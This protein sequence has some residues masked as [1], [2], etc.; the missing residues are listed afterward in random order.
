M[1]SAACFNLCFPSCF[2]FSPN[3]LFFCSFSPFF[4]LR[5]SMKMEIGTCLEHA[6]DQLRDI[7]NEIGICEDQRGERQNVVLHHI[8]NLLSEM[9]TEEESLRQRL[10]KS[11]ASSTEKVTTLCIELALQQYEVSLYRPWVEM[12]VIK[13]LLNYFIKEV[14]E[15]GLHLDFNFSFVNMCHDTF[16]TVMVAVVRYIYHLG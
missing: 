9:V 14:L 6:L 1:F 11:V 5:E 15:F 4:H 16:H 7:W 8:R 12:V 3:L 2:S 10:M 13:H